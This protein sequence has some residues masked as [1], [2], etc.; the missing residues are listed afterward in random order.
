MLEL[1][2]YFEQCS[3]SFG[4][5]AQLTGPYLIRLLFALV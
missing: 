2:S 1:H 4:L 3:G 5:D